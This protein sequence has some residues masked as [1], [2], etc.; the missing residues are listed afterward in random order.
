M[1]N[2]DVFYIVRSPDMER[3]KFGITSGDPRPRPSKH[4]CD[5]Y[6]ERVLLLKG[7]PGTLAA[8]IEDGVI[9]A[10][11]LAGIEPVRAQFGTTT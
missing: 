11:A 2:A 6:T 8:E 4:R 7:L 5:G 9:S 10:L 3:I 1:G